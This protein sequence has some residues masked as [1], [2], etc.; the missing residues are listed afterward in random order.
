MPAANRRVVLSVQ[1]I[2]L[3]CVE[4]K[5]FDIVTHGRLRDNSGRKGN[6]NHDLAA[7]QAFPKVHPRF[8]CMVDPR[9]FR[10]SHTCIGS[11]WLVRL[12]SLIR[13]APRKG[14]YHAP[15]RRG[16]VDSVLQS[17]S[18]VLCVRVKRGVFGMLREG[19]LR[20]CRFRGTG[21]NDVAI[22]RAAVL[23]YRRM[24]L[25][26][27]RDDASDGWRCDDKIWYCTATRGET[28]DRCMIDRS[29]K[30]RKTVYA[31]ELP[32][33]GMLVLQTG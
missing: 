4:F 9:N 27:R 3:I 7:S 24:S 13:A 30:T 2:H 12:T 19:Y 22:L 23:T 18:W 28:G 15:P 14:T 20:L 31:V 32:F 8:G 17:Y 5:G 1:G 10:P 11:V 26:G 16:Y 33:A 21:E 29:T 25:Q 6:P